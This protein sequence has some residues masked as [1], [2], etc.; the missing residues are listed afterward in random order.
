VL[1]HVRHVALLDFNELLFHNFF[2]SLH[3]S[4]FLLHASKDLSV[5][6]QVTDR[7]IGLHLVLLSLIGKPAHIRLELLVLDAQ[8]RCLLH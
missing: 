1:P 5:R 7:F 8:A 4:E 6:L 2:L 3:L